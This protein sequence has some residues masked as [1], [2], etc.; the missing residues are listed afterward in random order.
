MANCVGYTSCNTIVDI[1]DCVN[2]SDCIWNAGSCDCVDTENY[3]LSGD[4]LNCV[5]LTAVGLCNENNY[6]SLGCEWNDDVEEE[7]PPGYCEANDECDECHICCLPQI[8]EE[9]DCN[10]NQCIPCPNIYAPGCDSCCLYFDECG[11]CNG[12]GIINDI[13]IICDGDPFDT[14]CAAVGNFCTNGS[15]IEN[16]EYG[17]CNYFECWN[18]EC[19]CG[20]TYCS[21]DYPW[22]SCV[23]QNTATCLY[24][25]P[26]QDFGEPDCFDVPVNN[27]PITNTTSQGLVPQTITV[28]INNVDVGCMDTNSDTF[29]EEAIAPC[30][31]TCYDSDGN[32]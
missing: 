17:Q 12:R 10:V 29:D 9:Y 31:K 25:P 21:D 6:E 13:E 2:A 27:S 5:Y 15:C 20:P 14:S 16:P 8:A 1:E 22:A 18:N 24:V 26:L 4:C 32:S 7:L 11:V 23:E 30:A 28:C 19:T 3:D